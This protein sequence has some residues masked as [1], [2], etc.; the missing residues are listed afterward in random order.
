MIG[1]KQFYYDKPSKTF[2]ADASDFGPDGHELIRVWNDSCDEGVE[3]VSHVTGVSC[4]FV[5]S[6]SIFENE[7]LTAW[8]YTA[9]GKVGAGT[10]VLIMND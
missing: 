1:T 8:Q 3:L 6:G 9:I 4:K 10:K 2:V 5:L 7:E